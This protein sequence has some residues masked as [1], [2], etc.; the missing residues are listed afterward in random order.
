MSTPKT[1]PENKRACS[2]GGEYKL[3]IIRGGS[4]NQVIAR[5]KGCGGKA[6]QVTDHFTNGEI[7]AFLVLNALMYP[8]GLMERRP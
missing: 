7:D 1:E 8:F 6:T 5:C 3:A 4:S 2:C